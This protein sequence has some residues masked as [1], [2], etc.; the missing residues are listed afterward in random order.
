M[1]RFLKQHSGLAL[2]T[3]L[4][5]CLLAGSVQSED[6]SSIVTLHLVNGRTTIGSVDAETNDLHLV[7]RRSS[8][9]VILRT[10]VR[11]ASI[12]RIDIDD[13]PVATGEL[14]QRLPE[15]VSERPRSVFADASSSV[16]IQSQADR[17]SALVSSTCGNVVTI[18]S[19]PREPVS[20]AAVARAQVKSLQFCTQPANWDNDAEIDGLQIQVRPV[21]ESGR[22]V[23]VNGTLEIKLTGL[24]RTLGGQTQPGLSPVE[25]P[26]LETWSQRVRQTDFTNEGAMYRLVFRHDSPDRDLSIDAAG[27][28]SA[29]LIVPG[30]G[31][32]AATEPLTLL[33]PYSQMRDQHQ[34]FRGTRILPSEF[35]N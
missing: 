29:R 7:I 34:M 19:S 17:D 2:L 28:T 12:S 24:S 11:W 23:R 27:L 13:R 26:V 30:V 1:F 22:L 5:N 31:T 9:N 8:A 15:L 20:V 16:K 14:K 3:T 10:K 4:L 25:F 33:R 32:M 35:H 18:T 6:D 21:D